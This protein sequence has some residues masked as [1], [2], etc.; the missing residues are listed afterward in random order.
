MSAKQRHD[1]GRQKR[2]RNAWLNP[3]PLTAAERKDKRAGLRVK[4]TWKP[5]PS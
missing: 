4:R 2:E 1:I 5:K 3:E